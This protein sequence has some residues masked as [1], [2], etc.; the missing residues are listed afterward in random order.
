M[1]Y[2]PAVWVDISMS[3]LDV[4]VSWSGIRIQH[5]A[6]AKPLDSF[7]LYFTC[8]S[9]L[10]HIWDNECFYGVFLSLILITMCARSEYAVSTFRLFLLWKDVCSCAKM[11]QCNKVLYTVELSTSFLWFDCLRA[12]LWER[13]RLL[14]CILT[15]KSLH[16]NRRA[17]EE[18]PVP[19]HSADS[20]VYTCSWFRFTGSSRG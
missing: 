5:Q 4:G 18:P 2:D 9:V 13:L 15:P 8:S 10:W 17:E 12:E 1:N 3:W 16:C 20:V 19:S 7:H 14:W 6:R 11:C